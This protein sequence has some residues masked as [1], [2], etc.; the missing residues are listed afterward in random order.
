VT[1]RFAGPWVAGVCSALVFAAAHGSL[2]ALLPL[3]IFGLVLVVIYEK[4]GSLWA[5]I[6]VHFCFNG[7][8]VLVQLAVRFLD[9]PL[10]SLQ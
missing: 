5:P 6:A 1:K 3:F 8:T 9:I 10:E 2:S 7:A 4:T